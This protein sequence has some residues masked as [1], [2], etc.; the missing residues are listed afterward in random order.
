MMPAE[1]AADLG[2]AGM[3]NLVCL[4]PYYQSAFALLSKLDTLSKRRI[5][6]L[7]KKAVCRAVDNLIVRTVKQSR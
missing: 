3:L 5:V 2:T 7:L 1:L 4:M 6:S